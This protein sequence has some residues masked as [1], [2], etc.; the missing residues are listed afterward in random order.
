MSISGTC[1]KP[2]FGCPLAG[3]LA[4]LGQPSE[5]LL[6]ILPMIRQ[7]HSMGFEDAEL[8]AY[9]AQGKERDRLGD[10]KGVVDSLQGPKK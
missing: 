2:T 6:A 10:P 8:W 1:F 7:A 4:A 3:R 5:E 9:Y